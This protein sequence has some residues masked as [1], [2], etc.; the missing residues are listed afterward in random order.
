MI[1]SLKRNELVIKIEYHR[2]MAEALQEDSTSKAHHIFSKE[3][4][5]RCQA[6]SEEATMKESLKKAAAFHIKMRDEY[7]KEFNSAFPEQNFEE[8]YL[9]REDWM[10]DEIWSKA[11]PF[12]DPQLMAKEDA[13]PKNR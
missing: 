3:E 4:H 13:P 6:L 12:A 9:K 8:I 1:D 11:T 2:Q 5:E 10:L 7:L